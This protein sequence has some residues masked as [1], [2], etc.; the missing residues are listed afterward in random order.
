MFLSD[1]YNVCVV[2]GNLVCMLLQPTDIQ[3]NFFSILLKSNCLLEGLKLYDIN[4]L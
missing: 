1:K 4:R 2:A 3:A